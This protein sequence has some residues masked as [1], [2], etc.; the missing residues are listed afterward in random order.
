MKKI[1]I[2]EMIKLWDFI[3]E[4]MG[5]KEITITEKFAIAGVKDYPGIFDLQIGFDE[6]F[7]WLSDRHNTI[8][9]NRLVSMLFVRSQLKSIYL[10]YDD[11]FI[12]NKLEFT[13]GMVIIKCHL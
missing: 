4:F 3:N 5:G 8:S 12:I 9:D 10:I 6:E 2:D 13:D 7:A 11:K 1:T